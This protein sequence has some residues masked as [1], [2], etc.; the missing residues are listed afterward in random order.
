MLA[1]IG[2]VLP[3]VV[4][5]Y[6]FG[7]GVGFE[8]YGPDL[9]QGQAAINRP[10]FTADLPTD[11]IPAMPDVHD[12][13]QALP[14]ARVA[15]VGC[16]TGWSTVALATAFPNAQIDGFDL[17]VASLNEARTHA[18]SAGVADRVTFAGTDLADAS[19]A[20]R[21]DFACIFEAL[22]D[23]SHPVEVLRAIRGMLAPGAS[24]LVVDERV[25]EAF[26][27]P[28]DEV[29]RMMYGWSVLHCLPAA[30]VDPGSAATGTVL[31]PA[32]LREYAAAA[33]FT[34]VEVLDVANDFFRLYRL[35]G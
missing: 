4:D 25:A 35:R 11:W 23:M 33:G 5:A 12:R 29:E 7:G 28:G 16:G 27:A 18:S 19:L 32:K 13:L 21:Y 17:D 15:D 30:M 26:T 20:Q 10:A 3:N 9:R 2:S 8:E 6:K 1:G 34:D 31:R 14:P 24:L 22:H